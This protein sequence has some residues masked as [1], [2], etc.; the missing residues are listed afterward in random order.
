M[1]LGFGITFP[2]LYEREGLIRSI[3]RSVAY[4]ARSRPRA[5]RSAAAARDQPPAGTARVRAPDR[6]RAARRGF[7]RQALRHRARSAG[8]RR[9]RT[10]SSRRSTP[11]SAS[12]CS[13]ARCTRSSPTSCD[14]FDRARHRASA[15]I[16]RARLRAQGDRLAGRRSGAR[17]AARR[18]RALRRMGRAH[19]G[20]QGASIAAACC[21]RRRASST[22]CGLVPVHTE[23]RSAASPSTTLE[24]LRRRD[25][26]A[27]TDPGTIS[28]ARSTRRTTAS[29]PR[30]G[31]G[32]VLEGPA[33]KRRTARRARSRRTRSASRSPAARSTRRSPRCTCCKTRGDPIGALAMIVRRQ[34]DVPRH[35]PPHLQRLHEGVHLPEAGAGQHPAD[36][37]AR[38]DRRA[39]AAVGLRDLRPAHALEPAQ[40]ARAR[41]ALPYNGKNVLVVGLGPAGFTL[42][43]YLLNEGFG[44]VGIDGL[45]IE[46]LPSRRSPASTRTARA[47][48]SA[49]PRRRRAARAARRARAG[50]LRRRLRVRHHR[51]LGQELPH[52]HPPAAR[53]PR[54]ASRMYGGV[55]FGGTLTDRGRLALGFD[56]VAIAAGAGRPTIIDMKNN[57]TRGIRKASRLPDGAAAH[58]RV[59]ARVA[60]R[61]CRCGCRRRHRRRPDRAS[62]RRP[63]CSPT[64]RC[65]S[66][67]SSRATRR[68][69]ATRRSRA[70]GVER[71]GARDRRRVPRARARDPRRAGAATRE[72]R[73][74][75]HLELLQALGRR[76]DRLSPPPDRQPGVHAQPRGSEKALEEGI[77]FAEGLTPTAIEVD[78][79]GHAR[80][81]DARPM[82][83]QRGRAAARTVLSPPARNPTRCSRARTA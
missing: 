27:L 14:G 66:R 7:H 51:A 1:Q 56:H 81:V 78:E 57:L 18:R 2:D 49:D 69:R 79:Y 20:G 31:Q 80:A 4:L 3:A 13:A 50:G 35:R 72:K 6:A 24:H 40:R 15:A 28:S 74:R 46:P 55:R 63:S 25:G 32:L 19:A 60:R 37:D 54:A 52:A 75:A 5:C 82:R 48:R 16:H 44:V 61:T 39:R 30:A 53:A 11:S 62:T 12:S 76:D 33:R 77:S 36:R 17:R 64:T 22:S 59:Q 42:A 38:A 58:R 26:F 9:A 83:R 23:I 45:K 10:T 29:V 65:R 34:P 67:S 68:L 47:C 70:P 21:S 73:E 71:G 41:I 43:H 8:A